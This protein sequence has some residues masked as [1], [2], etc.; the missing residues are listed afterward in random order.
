MAKALAHPL[1]VQLLSLL[2]EGVSSP[3]ELAKKLDEPLT[4]VS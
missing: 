2:N 3:N 1:R 4:N